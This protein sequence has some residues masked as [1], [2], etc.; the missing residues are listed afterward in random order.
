MARAI[1][2]EAGGGVR[3]DLAG[4]LPLESRKEKERKR[5]EE[6]ERGLGWGGEREGAGGGLECPTPGWRHCPLQDPRVPNDRQSVMRFGWL[7]KTAP[8]S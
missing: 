4:E 5:E 2:Y 1:S 7:R 6:R 8:G 3:G